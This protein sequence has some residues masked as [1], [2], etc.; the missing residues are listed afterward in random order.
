MLGGAFKFLKLF[1]VTLQIMLKILIVDGDL[2][3]IYLWFY[4]HWVV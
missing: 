4:V 2:L 1:T 3:C